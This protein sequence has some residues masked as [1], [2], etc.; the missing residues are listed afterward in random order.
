MTQVSKKSFG[1]MRTVTKALSPHYH[2]S[3]PPESLNKRIVS[4]D[5]LSKDKGVCEEKDRK[6]RK[7]R[8]CVRKDR[9]VCEEKE[10]KTQKIQKVCTSVTA[11][12]LTEFST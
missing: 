9:G 6:Q 10:H 3:L 1:Y 11:S 5:S 8:E 2:T 12:L 7:Y 4:D